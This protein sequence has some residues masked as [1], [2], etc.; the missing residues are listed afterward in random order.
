MIASLGMYD[1][2]WV[3]SANDALWTGIA[4]R[5]RAAGVE[6]VPDRLARDR[7]LTEIW[8][9]PD[10]LLG[11]T[12]G[13][14][15]VTALQ[16]VVQV[17][18]APVYDFPGC[19]GATHRSFLVVPAASSFRSLEDLR[20]HRVAINS[21]DSNTGMNLLRRAVAP[22]AGGKPFFGAVATTGAHLASL[23]L[24]AWNGAD[25][26]AIDCVSFGLAAR[27]RPELVSS[28]RII[29][30]TPPSPSLPFVTRG[31]ASPADIAILREALAGALA[32][33]SLAE[34]KQAIGLLG[35]EPTTVEDYEI[36]ALYE[37]EAAAMGHPVVA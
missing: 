8:H 15:L 16:G 31:G 30:E 18:A 24:V 23:D 14:P 34:A 37:R 1:M 7:A 12:C 32:D 36:V 21:A 26:A 13:Y 25:L 17:V 28:V 9:D 22:L 35:V 27:H 4:A 6:S 11:Q 19:E 5:L 33:R 2:D 10:L 20:G 29:G 3:Q